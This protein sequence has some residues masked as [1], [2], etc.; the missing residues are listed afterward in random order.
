M[1]MYAAAT[2]D[3][4]RCHYDES[5]AK[6][7]GFARAFVDGQMLGAILAKQVMDWAGP[8]AFLR[9]LAYRARRM[10]YPDETLVSRGQVVET[11]PQD[12]GGLAVCELS[13]WNEENNEVVK[14]AR[15]T[16]A[17]PSR[18]ARSRHTS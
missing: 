5:Y 14:Q 12:V 2:W 10:V 18:A 1:V 17:L 8:D 13:I 15:A 4:H 11:T 7:A 16:V 9:R 3:F 6:A